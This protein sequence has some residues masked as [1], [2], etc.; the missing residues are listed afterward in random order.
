MTTPTIS[1]PEP[2]VRGCCLVGAPDSLYT[3]DQLLSH[4]EEYAAARVAEIA[5]VLSRIDYLCGP[6]NDM[7]CSLYDADCDEDRV[8]AAVEKRFAELE[9]E[10]SR[11]KAEREARKGS[12]SERLHNLCAA[13]AK[14]REK[15]DPW[16][17]EALQEA[18]A[19][20][21]RL[22]QEV[23]RLREDA[24]RYRWTENWLIQHG[25]L[26]AQRCQPAAGAPVGDWW[27]LRSPKI[28]NGDGIVGIGKTEA[29][30]IDAAR[31]ALKEQEQRGN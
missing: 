18:D 1:L 31:A 17:V 29:A 28:I 6:P 5:R 21:V 14:D 9:A 23:S 16:T 24:D 13:L 30:A 8:L 10:V 19:E 20:N 12:P 11:L 3:A 4:R 7:Q 27:L 15:S 22:Q 2:A 26:A 25:L